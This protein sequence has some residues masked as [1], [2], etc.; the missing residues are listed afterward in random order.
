MGLGHEP[1]CLGRPRRHHQQC[2][3]AP[4]VGEPD[5]VRSCVV[6]PQIFRTPSHRRTPDPGALARGTG[7]LAGRTELQG[8]PP[9]VKRSNV[10]LSRYA[11]SNEKFVLVR[12][13]ITAVLSFDS[14][15]MSDAGSRSYSKLKTHN[16]KRK[17]CAAAFLQVG[18]TQPL[19]SLSSLI[20]G[21]WQANREC[22]T[23]ADNGLDGNGT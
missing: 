6:R 8:K 15:V 11:G 17:G 12:T 14:P 20:C 18:V 19:P 13:G 10:E 2:A 16:S 5:D 22:R 21:Q 23:N 1:V 9:P 7:S 4:D 3:V